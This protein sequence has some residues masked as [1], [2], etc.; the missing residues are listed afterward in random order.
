MPC[1]NPNHWHRGYGGPERV[2]GW[3]AFPPRCAD[4]GAPGAD[5]YVPDPVAEDDGR[6]VCGHCWPI[7]QEIEAEAIST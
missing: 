4:C 6:W 3:V 7:V 5:Y 1:S 2:G